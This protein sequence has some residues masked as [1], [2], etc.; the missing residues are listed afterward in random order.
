MIYGYKCRT[1]GHTEDSTVRA[2]MIG[3]CGCGGWLTR[4]YQFVVEPVMQEHFNRAV[5]MPISSMRQFKRELDRV[6]DE[7]SARTGMDTKFAPIDYADTKACGVTGDG[8]DAMNRRRHA[9]GKPEL[10]VKDPATP[11]GI[12]P[13]K[14]PAGPTRRIELPHESG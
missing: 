10:V 11:R 14:W 7:Y 1:C 12:P 2:N 5:G 6:S 4:K 9:E 13:M 8:L 3:P